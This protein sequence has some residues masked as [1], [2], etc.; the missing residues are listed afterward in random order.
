M[1]LPTD[2]QFF[3]KS[4]PALPDIAFLKNHLYREGRLTEEQALFIIRGGAKLLKEEP[5]L[6]DV[7]SPV[8]GT[9]LPILYPT[10]HLFQSRANNYPFFVP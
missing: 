2:S 5:N 10:P 6:L 3:S 7:E 1:S 4:N 9:L 8:T